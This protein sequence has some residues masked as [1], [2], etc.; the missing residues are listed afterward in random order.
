[1]NELQVFD[2]SPMIYVGD[3]GRQES[4]YSLRVGGIRFLLNHL[5][6]AFT[7]RDKVVLCFDSPSFRKDLFQG[8]KSG[9]PNE[10]A[11]HYQVNAMY[12]ELRS[13]GIRC[14]KYDGYEADDI[15][16]WAVAQ[17]IE[18]FIRGVTIYSNDHDICHSIR[19]GV[20]LA[21]ITNSM[22]DISPSNFET[23]ISRGEKIPYNTISAQKVFCGCSSD[24]IPPLSI[25]AGYSGK[26]LYHAW[27]KAVSKVGSLASRKLGANP[28]VVT[29]F[30][31]GSGLFTP[32]ELEQVEK[33]IKLIYPADPPEGVE[34]VPVDYMK[35]VDHEK[36]IQVCQKYGAR[37]AVT[38]LGE[39]QRKLT[40]EEIQELRDAAHRV[41]SGEYAAD[42]NL[43]HETK[44]VKSTL[45]DLNSFTR[46]FTG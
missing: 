5:A 38:C 31:K 19:N 13:C 26:Q 34:I 21:A 24:A 25:A 39:R 11:I 7:D 32:E 16:E 20:M 41:N 17:N 14:E 6:V 27:C 33:R 10:P 46:G 28:A 1:M 43:I 4:Y 22:N 12:D 45:V 29:A 36:F 23:A 3:K 40:Q 15:V 18:K 8:Y 2:V 9:R 44:S 30:A 35:D 37:D 42:K